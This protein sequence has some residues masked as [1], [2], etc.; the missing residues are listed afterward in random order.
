M[1]RACFFDLDGASIFLS[2][3]SHINTEGC[4]Q[5]EDSPW[6]SI[7]L[8]NHCE[9]SPG[10]FYAIHRQRSLQHL[11]RDCADG[12]DVSVVDDQLTNLCHL[13]KCYKVC[14]IAWFCEVERWSND[15]SPCLLSSKSCPMS[16]NLWSSFGSP[17]FL[18]RS[19][20]RSAS[21]A[22]PLKS[23]PILVPSGAFTW[24]WNQIYC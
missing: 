3:F 5:H 13:G 15:D 16:A 2:H 6:R 12:T 22:V 14:Q 18:C 11:E 1:T 9:V 17:R 23:I 10:N 19:P 7:S 8:C 21:V 4:C 24:T 20:F